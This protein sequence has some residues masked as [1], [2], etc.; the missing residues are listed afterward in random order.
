MVKLLHP[1][2]CLWQG[3]VEKSLK[4]PKIIDALYIL[5]YEVA[6]KSQKRGGEKIKKSEYIP[7]NTSRASV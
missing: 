7:L 2:V 5:Y 4:R 3:R 6:S 1:C